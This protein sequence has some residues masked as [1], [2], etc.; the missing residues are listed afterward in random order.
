M[1]QNSVHAVTPPTQQWLTIFNTNLSSPATV[2]IELTFLT[3]V[4]ATSGPQ[5]GRVDFTD[6]HVAVGGDSSHPETPFPQGCTATTTSPQERML[7][8]LFF[9]TPTC[10]QSAP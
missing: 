7:E 5:C 8:F 3:P 6:L 4:E 1:A 9:D 10:A 2:P